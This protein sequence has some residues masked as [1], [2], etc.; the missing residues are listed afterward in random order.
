M[1]IAIMWQNCIRHE[2]PFSEN[3]WCNKTQGLEGR[4]SPGCRASLRLRRTHPAAADVAFK[5]DRFRVM[6]LSDIFSGDYSCQ[7]VSMYAS[8]RKR[9]N[10]LATIDGKLSFFVP[11]ALRLILCYLLVFVYHHIFSYLGHLAW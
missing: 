4:Y 3:S 6:Y 11:L 9:R 8:C 10:F 1:I 5:R 7:P 2:N